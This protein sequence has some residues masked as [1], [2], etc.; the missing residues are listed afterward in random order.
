MV[1]EFLWIITGQNRA[2]LIGK[3]NGEMKR[4]SDDGHH[5]SGAYG[6]PITDQLPWIIRQIKADPDTRQAV[7]TIWRPLPGESK[8]IPCTIVMQFMLRKS[9]LEM[10][11]YMRSNDLWLGFPYD[12]FTFTMIQRYVASALGVPP[13]PY[14][15]HVGS[16]HLYDRDL[17]SVKKALGR[18]HRCVDTADLVPSYPWPLEILEC[19]VAAPNAVRRRT[20]STL[21]DGWWNL[22][23]L[24][25]PSYSSQNPRWCAILE[26]HGIEPRG[27]KDYL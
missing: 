6:P 5:L 25:I 17:E 26:R 2:D 10:L 8:D 13:G 18:P 12:L 16:L 15:H 21:P 7:L 9:G 11:T 3:F 20:G 24:L 4:F 1:A 27:F 14:H 22:V 19:L 23:S